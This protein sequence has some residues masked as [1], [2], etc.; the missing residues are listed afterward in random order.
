MEI[1]GKGYNKV[2]RS[3]NKSNKL[4]PNEARPLLAGVPVYSPVETFIQNRSKNPKW[5]YSILLQ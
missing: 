1:T 5:I 2:R 4:T 3:S